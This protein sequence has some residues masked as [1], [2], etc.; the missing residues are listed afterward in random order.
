MGVRVRVRVR[1]TETHPRGEVE[2][3]QV[4]RLDLEPRQ[5]GARLKVRARG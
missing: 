1:V 5:R 4:D 3:V 2:V